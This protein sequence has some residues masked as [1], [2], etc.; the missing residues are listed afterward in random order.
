VY[1]TPEQFFDCHPETFFSRTDGAYYLLKPVPALRPFPEP[2][3]IEAVDPRRVP[4]PAVAGARQLFHSGT[5]EE[6]VE[7][8]VW[9]ILFGID[10]LICGQHSLTK[11]IGCVKVPRDG[12]EK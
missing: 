7:Q 12:K 11:I 4:E 8:K 5:L 2:S 9:Q 3:E 6:N 10:P 1:G